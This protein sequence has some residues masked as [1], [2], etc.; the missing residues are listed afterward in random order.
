MATSP[1]IHGNRSTVS[2]SDVLEALGNSLGEI[3]AT[4]RLTYGD[5]GVELGKSEDVAAS[6]RAATSDMP[7]T[8]FFRG[9]GKWGSRF[10]GEA[11]RKHGFKLVPIDATGAPHPVQFAT[12]LTGTAHDTLMASLDGIDPAEAKRLLP[13]VEASR[14]Q[15][16]AFADELRIIAAR[17][18]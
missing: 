4:D 6:Y 10:A 13:G 18:A 12:S 8:A 11:I 15:A 1:Q 17:A 2:A 9:L 14:D 5:L 3:K 16:A 7:V